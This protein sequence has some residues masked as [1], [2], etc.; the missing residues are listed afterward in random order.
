M[1][2]SEIA[3]ADRHASSDTVESLGS[4]PEPGVRDFFAGDPEG[5]RICERI[6]AT[7]GAIGTAEVRISKSQVAFR[8]RRGF[9]YVWRP[10]MYLRPAG[11]PAVLSIALPRR[12]DSR[13]FKSV[14]HPSRRVWMHHLE[15]RKASEVD[16]EVAHWLRVAY[17]S[18]ADEA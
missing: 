12:L 16:D 8:R 6:A 11:V 1:A 3:G 4:L 2:R 14:V 13:R 7:I 18:A 5:L 10:D 17:W 9:A 15:L